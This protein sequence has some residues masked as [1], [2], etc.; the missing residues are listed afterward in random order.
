MN[1][2][3]AEQTVRALVREIDPARERELSPEGFEALVKELAMDLLEQIQEVQTLNQGEPVT[4]PEVLEVATE[5]AKGSLRE[6][7]QAEKLKRPSAR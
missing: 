7:L 4:A 1:L 2:W 3:T 6:R 5:A